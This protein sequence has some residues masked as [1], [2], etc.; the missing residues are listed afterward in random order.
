VL[1]S[2]TA[3]ITLSF[4]ACLKPGDHVLVTDSAYKS[5]RTLCETLMAR[6]GVEA[7]YFR[8]DAGGAI[9]DNIRPETRLVFWSLRGPT[10]SKSRTFRRSPKS[11]AAGAS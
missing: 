9:E 1:A 10:P 4:M 5:T 7:S 3:A 2:G 8:P 11:A 6:L